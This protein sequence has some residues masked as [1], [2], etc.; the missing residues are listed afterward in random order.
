MIKF[1]R[2]IRYKLM[3][4]GKTSKYF[5]YAIGEIVLVVIGILIAIQINNWNEKRKASA[6]NK[7]LLKQVHKELAFNIEKANKLIEFY[8]GKDT[9]IYKIIMKNVTYDDY[10]TNRIYS[11]VLFASMEVN[12]AND[13]YLNFM[14]N[15]NHSN[16]DQ[17]SIILKLKEL[18]R[19]DK[20]EV[21]NFDDITLTRFVEFAERRKLNPWYYNYAVLKETTDEMISYLLNDIY[22]LNEIVLY[23]NRNLGDHFNYTRVFRNKAKEVYAELS[24]YLAIEKD[25]S[26]VKNVKDY[27]HY[28]GTYIRE[29]TENK[30]VIG[31]RN[32]K[33]Y[34]TI[35]DKTETTILDE[36]IF[37]PDSKTD[38]TGP[39]H[40]FGKLRYNK[41]NEVV[42]FIRTNVNRTRYEYRKIK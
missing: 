23:Q 28:T 29:G 38:F 35:K 27:E 8:R 36:Y 34:F 26:I 6:Y 11:S 39:G 3:T 31:D 5:K 30:F 33:L 40:A 20:N 19:T 9:L 14:D 24:D 22:Y 10:K 7:T 41:D 42:G 1:F 2:K 16:Q 4:T 25:T 12:L 18:Y 21:D 37:Y 32:N 17:E 15:Q 13:D